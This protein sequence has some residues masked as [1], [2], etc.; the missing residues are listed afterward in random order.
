[1]L[2]FVFTLC[3]ALLT[4]I[5]F[6]IVPALAASRTDLQQSLREGGRGAT[7][8]RRQHLLRDLLAAGETGLACV[9]LIAAGLMLHSFVNLLRADP[10]FRPQQVLTASIALPSEQYKTV[11][12]VGRFCAQVIASLQALPQVRS[13]GMATDLPW[14]GYDENSG[15]FTVEGRPASYNEQT[16]ARYHAASLDY[17]SALGVPLLRGRLFTD[18]DDQDAPK[19]LLINEAM[20]KR[21]WPGEDAIG[22]RMSFDGKNWLGV[23]G[24]VGDVR[25][26]ASSTVTHPAFW[27]PIMQ[28]P[29]PIRA[30]SV[31]IHT[32]GN[33]ALLVNQL[34]GAVHQF[35]PGLA[36]GDLRVMEQIVDESV[37]TQRFALFLIA[38]FA[39]LALTLAT[40]GMYGV[41]SYSVN[42]RMH[43][44]GMR[45]ALGAKPSDL[46]R[47]VLSHGIKLSMI[48]SAIG[49]LCAAAFARL[50]GSLL[51]GV[52]G[53]DPVTFAS[54]AMVALATATLACYLPARRATSADPMQ[55]LRSE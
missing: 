29:F 24:V 7:A 3:I 11:P 54:I 4:G 32:S 47:L 55:S 14:T 9:L 53:A 38:L 42:Q 20:A 28:M 45:I 26:Q 10:G 51:Y 49:L 18:H 2:V 23:V 22:K 27:W 5:L 17:F 36:V 46:M 6:G 33:P 21:Y 50:M 34:R 52:S 30:L 25:D 31:A 12:E 1:L 37:S 48:G 8:G 44:F 40:I 39:A 43:E 16:T 35:N 19:V 13:A 15:G 41:I